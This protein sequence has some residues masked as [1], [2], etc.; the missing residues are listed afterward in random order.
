MKIETGRGVTTL[1]L[2][3][4]YK[5][6][7]GL[8]TLRMV[9]KGGT[10]E[11]S[12]FVSVSGEATWRHTAI[13]PRCDLASDVVILNIVVI[14]AP[15]C[16]DVWARWSPPGPQRAWCS[17]GHQDPRCQQR[18]RHR[19]MEAPQHHHGGAHPGILCGQVGESEHAHHKY[20]NTPTYRPTSGS[21]HGGFE[22]LQQRSSSTGGLQRCWGGGK[23]AV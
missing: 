12:A 15:Y 5:D 23:T 4:L 1:T 9:T 18:L 8:Y 13:L 16:S 20:I 17:H 19:V 22:R 10:A 6:D 14:I 11:H 7:E 21:H 3:N 2:P